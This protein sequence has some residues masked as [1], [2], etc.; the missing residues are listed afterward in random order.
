MDV[1]QEIKSLR[2]AFETDPE[3]DGMSEEQLEMKIKNVEDAFFESAISNAQNKYM[4]NYKKDRKTKKLFR[5]LIADINNTKS[6]K[7]IIKECVRKKM[8][9]V[10]SPS[11]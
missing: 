5:H 2:E 11:I 10:V 6:Y 3:H 9:Q 1:D 7:E 8:R 4:A